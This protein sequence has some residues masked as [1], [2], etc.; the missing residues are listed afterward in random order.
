MKKLFFDSDIM[1]DISLM[2][3]PFCLPAIN[4]AE[5]CYQK[6]FRAFTSAV[7]FVNVN[8]FLS[9]LAPKTRLP[10]LQRLRSIISII[11][12]DEKIIDLALSSDFIDFEDAVQ[13]YAAKSSGIEAIITRNIKD[14]KES[15]IPVLTAEEFLK[16]L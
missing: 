2:R 12:V 7:A 13:F 5:L 16:T 15:K 6:R 4:L 14:Y 8:Y 3:E 11:E 10:S 9:K 1:L